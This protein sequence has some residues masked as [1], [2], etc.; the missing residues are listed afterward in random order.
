MPI[1]VQLVRT[2]K[3]VLVADDHAAVMSF[4]VMLPSR[5]VLVTQ[6]ESKAYANPRHA[7]SIELG[8]HL[9][10]MDLSA[11]PMMGKSMVTCMRQPEHQPLLHRRTTIV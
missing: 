6:M 5:R 7:L 9:T 1:E 4:T 3:R 2:V 11:S 10:A 8:T